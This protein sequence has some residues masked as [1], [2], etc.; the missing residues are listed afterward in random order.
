MSQSIRL[1]ALSVAGLLLV[2]ACKKKPETAPAP[3]NSGPA[4]TETCDAAC[5]AARAAAEKAARDSADAAR[6]RAEREALERATGALR[7]TLAQK[8]YFDYDQAELSG[9]ATSVLDAKLAIILANAG[10]RLRISGH[11]DERG[12]DEYNLAL[13]Q[14]RAAAVKRFFTDRGVDASRIEVVSFGEERPEATDGTEDAY[15]LNRRAE[16]EITA[17]GDN[18]APPK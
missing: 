8:V 18:L 16:F 4:P 7:T 11:A 13:G 12:S 3:V 1:I 9:E 5:R 2:S 6:A 17:G 15:R 10:L 14:R